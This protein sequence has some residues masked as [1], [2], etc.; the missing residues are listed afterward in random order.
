MSTQIV[1][2]YIFRKQNWRG[3]ERKKSVDYLQLLQ[4]V[5]KLRDLQ[6]AA[7]HPAY[8]YTYVVCI[9]M[10]VVIYNFSYLNSHVICRFILKTSV[11]FLVNFICN[12]CT[13]NDTMH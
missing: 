11:N 9:Y 5:P 1:Y 13:L 7:K 2:M 12:I 3:R 6:P 10:Y 8:I 4:G